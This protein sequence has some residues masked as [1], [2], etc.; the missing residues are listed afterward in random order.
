MRDKIT[1]AVL[2]YNSSQILIYHTNS[3]DL[4]DF[5]E[6]GDEDQDDLVQSYLIDK[7]L[8]ISEVSYMITEDNVKI[9]IDK[10]NE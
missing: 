2:D 5:E 7:G 4:L 10:L 9:L 3:D 6:N 8:K 1:I